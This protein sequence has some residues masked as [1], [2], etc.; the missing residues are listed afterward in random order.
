MPLSEQEKRC[1]ELTCR[2]L[3]ARLG[4]AWQVVGWLDDVHPSKPTPEVVVS[5]GTTTAG[6]EVKR[7]MGDAIDR[8]YKESL[9]SNQK[10]LAPKCGGDYVLS[11]PDGFH[12]P[13]PVKLRRYLKR[14]I[15]RVAH[16]LKPGQTGAVR[17]ERQGHIALNSESGLPYISCLHGSVPGFHLLNPLLSRITG[18]FML[19]DDYNPQHSFITDQGREQFYEAVVSSCE[20]RLRG[21][22]SPFTWYEEWGIQRLEDDKDSEDGSDGV[23]I[24]ACGQA[25]SV[26]ESVAECVSEMLEKSLK[27]FSDKR[28]ADHHIVVLDDHAHNHEDMVIWVISGFDPEEL[29]SVDLIL[30][31]DGDRVVQCYP[32]PADSSG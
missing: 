19:V 7:L 28:W 11:P 29:R 3:A 27:K 25:R 32:V 4:G 12:P 31:V 10:F 2:F 8:A 22:A 23:W 18:S 5:N 6:V 17:I 9:L 26:K 20:R 14:E 16:S 24:F 30:L 1:I 21:D 13:I 15:E